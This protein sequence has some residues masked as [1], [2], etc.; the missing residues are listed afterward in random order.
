MKRGY[1]P[2]IDATLEEVARALFRTSPGFVMEKRDYRCSDCVPLFAAQGDCHWRTLTC[3]LEETVLTTIE[4]T[5]IPRPRF[6][7]ARTVA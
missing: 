7:I 5:I 6:P 4:D 1:P 2:R 3:D